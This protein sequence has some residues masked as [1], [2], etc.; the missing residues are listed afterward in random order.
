MS[1]PATPSN[2]DLFR[3]LA[4][5]ARE[6]R[7]GQLVLVV[8]V[9][10]AT[11]LGVAVWQPP[12]WPLVGSLSFGVAAFGAWGIADRE[13]IARDAARGPSWRILRLIRGICVLCGACAVVVALFSLLGVALGTWIS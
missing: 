7:D 1:I 2:D 10:L 13:L 8:L 12:A 11:A 6:M 5:H 9:G 4:A 3:T